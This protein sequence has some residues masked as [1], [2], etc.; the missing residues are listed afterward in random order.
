MVSPLA[1]PEKITAALDRTAKIAVVSILVAV[2]VMGIKYLAYL[3]TGSVALYSDALE[4]IVNVITAIAALVAVRISAQPPDKSHPYG[5]HKV[6]YFS[7]VLEGALIIV[8]ALLIIR[9]AW[10]A[11][12]MPHTIE[13]PALGLAI[14]GVATALNAGWSWFLITRGRTWRSPALVADGWH[15]FTDVATSL[16]VIVGLALAAITGWPILDPLLAAGVAFHILHAGFKLTREIG[17]QLDGR[18]GAAQRFRLVS[19]KP[20]R[21]TAEARCKCTTSGLAMRARPLSSNFIWW[22]RGRCLCPESH[23]ICDRLED[24]IRQ[25]IEG[26][27]VTIHVEPEFKAKT[28]GAVDL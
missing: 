11:L 24:A 12:L 3:E 25:S 7:A 5:H 16:G 13:A 2:T 1:Q 14:N 20:S 15:L 9:E 6:E 21:R 23:Q 18:G 26:A 27:Q 10:S 17:E 4:S 22:C 19:A 8:A 28:K